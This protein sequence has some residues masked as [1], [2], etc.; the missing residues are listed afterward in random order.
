QP[1]GGPDRGTR[2]ASV[3]RHPDRRGIL[4]RGMGNDLLYAPPRAARHFFNPLAPL[5]D[6]RPQVVP[7]E[8][9]QKPYDK[10]LPPHVPVVTNTGKFLKEK[11]HPASVTWV[12]HSAFA[13]QDGGDV[14]LTDPHFGRRALVPARVT[15]PG[16]PLEAVPAE[17]FAIL[18]HNHYDHMD[19][20]TIR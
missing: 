4:P 11:D 2:Y 8:L 20:W 18:S 6:T 16:I 19:E 5:R 15:P 9:R 7:G 17:A 10:N 13:V 14:F 12:G 1:S 3:E